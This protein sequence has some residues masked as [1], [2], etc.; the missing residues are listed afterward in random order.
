MQADRET[1]IRRTCAAA[2]PRTSAPNIVHQSWRTAE[3]PEVVANFVSGWQHL[4]NFTHRLWTDDAN[5]Q[6][7]AAHVPELLPQ[8]LPLLHDRSSPEKRRR[9]L[10]A[11]TKLLRSTGSP[12]EG[13]WPPDTPSPSVLL[14]PTLL[15]MLS[16]EHEPSSRLE[17]LRAL[18][19]LGAPK[20]STE[21]QARLALQRTTVGPHV[22]L[23]PEGA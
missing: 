5:R 20:P 18:G 10:R 4:S 6:L 15:G 2:F 13:S 8:L 3:I 9:A 14:L 17:L 19:L 7:F 12:T 16:T 21:V 1:W 23:A 11:L 22:V